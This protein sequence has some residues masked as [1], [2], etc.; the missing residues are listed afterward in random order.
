[1]KKTPL[2]AGMKLIFKPLRFSTYQPNKHPTSKRFI[3]STHGY[4][5]KLHFSTAELLLEYH[6]GPEMDKREKTNCIPTIFQRKNHHC[7]TKKGRSETTV[8][9]WYV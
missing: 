2:I 4:S 6:L 3:I 8:D 9:H 1:M 7:E 5:K